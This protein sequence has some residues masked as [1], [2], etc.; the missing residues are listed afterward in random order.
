M[1]FQPILSIE[2]TRGL[3]TVKVITITIDPKCSQT[4]LKALQSYPLKLQHL[5]RIQR[6]GPKNE[7]VL[8]L[9]SDPE[10][11]EIVKLITTLDNTIPFEKKLVSK[12][13]A[14]TKAQYN[15]WNLL[16]PMSFTANEKLDQISEHDQQIALYYLKKCKEED[17]SIIVNPTTNEII[18]KSH[19]SEFIL[20][21]KVMTSIGN[22]ANLE[23]KARRENKRKIDDLGYLC[24]GLDMYIV[25]EPCVM[26]SMALVHSRI[27]RL[28]YIDSDEFGGLGA[29]YSLHTLQSLNHKFKVWKVKLEFQ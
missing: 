29:M 12:Y 18:T 20:D 1:E 3:E 10:L 17:V 8:C 26:C 4:I 15:E 24:T 9:E 28:F 21:H 11:S 14:H 19:H 27:R 5:K 22:V 6:L 23:I 16:W 2:K 13:Q 7:L 25:K